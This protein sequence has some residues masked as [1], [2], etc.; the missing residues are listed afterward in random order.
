[1]RRVY[2]CLVLLL[3]AGCSG[4]QEIAREDFGQWT[5]GD[6]VRF[7][8]RSHGCGLGGTNE[9]FPENVNFCSVTFWMKTSQALSFSAEDQL[10]TYAEDEVA[11][12]GITMSRDPAAI[13]SQGPDPAPGEAPEVAAMEQSGE[14]V[15]NIYVQL[16]ENE[17]PD[18]FTLDPGNGTTYLFDLAG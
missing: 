8:L 10:F 4:P 18:T 9:L 6:G 14:A 15:V 5:T 13:N 12:Y 11:A 2:L 7:M 16:P 1:M 17:E 3:L